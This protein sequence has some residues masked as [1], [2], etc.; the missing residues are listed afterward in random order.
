MGPLSCSLFYMSSILPYNFSHTVWVYLIKH[1]S[2]A[3]KSLVTFYNMINIQFGKRIKKIKSNNGGEFVS[4]SMHDFYAE[5]GIFLETSCINTPQQN[6]VVKKKHGHT[7]QIA[8]ALRFGAN[9]PIKFW[10]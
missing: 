10:G 3:S 7:L 1:K 6:R 2:D 8:R 9:L 4:N 5:K